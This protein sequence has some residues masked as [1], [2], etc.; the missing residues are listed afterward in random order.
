MRRASHGRGRFVPVEQ[1][2]AGQ[3][4][5]KAVQ[6]AFLTGLEDA[7]GFPERPWRLIG[8]RV[9]ALTWLSR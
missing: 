3:A 6:S 7:A 4:F 2:A 1:L 5:H 9:V 8:E